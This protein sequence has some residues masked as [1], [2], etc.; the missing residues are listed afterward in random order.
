[1]QIE[2][3]LIISS[4]HGQ[5]GS[6]YTDLQVH[7]V[8]V[9]HGAALWDSSTQVSFKRAQSVTIRSR[10]ARV[11]PGELEARCDGPDYTGS[12]CIREGRTGD[13]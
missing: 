8:D 1:M 5:V 7:H 12:Q 10:S 9:R 6:F 3:A 11:L 4:F 13:G 2:W